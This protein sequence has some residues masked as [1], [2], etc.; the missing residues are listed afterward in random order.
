MISVLELRSVRG[1]GVGPEK[2]ILFGAERHDRR[3]FRI[4][5]CYLRDLRDEVFGIDERAR[6]LG[7]DYVEV[8]ERHSFDVRI[9]S[10]LTALAAERRFD[11]VHGH[12]Y[13]TN[14]L[15]W[16]LARRTGAVAMASVGRRV[17][18]SRWKSG[19]TRRGRRNPSRMF[20]IRLTTCSDGMARYS[21][22]L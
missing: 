21:C 2:T 15:A 14:L 7:L 18:T 16:L 6:T 12:D 5:V 13:K 9:W 11:I 8:R 10:Q 20:S 1:T 19:V 4:T 17:S 22:A 3:R